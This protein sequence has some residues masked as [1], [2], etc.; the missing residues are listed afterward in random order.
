MI[1]RE[2]WEQ[3]R[4]EALNAPLPDTDALMTRELAELWQVTHGHAGKLARRLV[5]V[6]KAEFT[7]KQVRRT[8]G[9]VV[10]VPAYRLLKGGRD[11]APK[12]TENARRNRR[13]GSRP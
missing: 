12:R 6:G 9:G 13:G 1:N 5:S 2:A 3:A 7:R 8:D 4:Q 11:D 10:W